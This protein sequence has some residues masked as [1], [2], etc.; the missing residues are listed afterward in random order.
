MEISPKFDKVYD[1][2]CTK[3]HSYGYNIYDIGLSPQRKLQ[4][5]T[6]H[7]QDLDK[8]MVNIDSISEYIQNIPHG[9]SNFL[10]RKSKSK[11]KS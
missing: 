7:L 11:S 1:T 5:N 2:L 10:F 3:L 8:L 9:Q 4:Q 6:N